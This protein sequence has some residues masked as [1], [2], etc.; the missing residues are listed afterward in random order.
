MTGQ[1]RGARS[2]IDELSLG[3]SLVFTDLRHRLDGDC[4]GFLV[5]IH[6]TT[7]FSFRVT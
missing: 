3:S 6:I 2:S 7:G 1:K 4:F 5:V